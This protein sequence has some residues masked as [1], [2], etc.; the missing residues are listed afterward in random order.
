MLDARGTL[1]PFAKAVDPDLPVTV[2]LAEGE[3]K[4][5]VTLAVDAAAGGVSRGSLP[6]GAADDLAYVM[7]TSGSTGVPKGVTISHRAARAFV[8]WC[9][10]RFQPCADDVFSS[11]APLHFDLSIHDI[12]RQIELCRAIIPH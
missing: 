6:E 5:G 7:Y 10:D 4:D 2:T 3:K 8:D 9:S 12:Q 11:H 1:L